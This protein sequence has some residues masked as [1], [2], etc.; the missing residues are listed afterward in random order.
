MTEG[1]D[2]RW[3]KGV[4][5]GAQDRS[6]AE[7]GALRLNLLADDLA[8]P[9]AVL[10]GSALEHNA[11]WMAEFA[12]RLGLSLAPHGKTTLSPELFELQL[13]HGAWAITAATAHHVRLYAEFGVT[14]ILMANQ[15]VGKANIAIVTELLKRK[16]ELE[17]ICLVDGVEGAT[18]LGRA[19][20]AAGLP[21]RLPVLLEVGEAGQRA[22]VRTLKDALAVARVCRSL[23]ALRLVG[24]E[25]FEGLFATA[26]GA[27]PMLDRLVEVAST[28]G[29]E[30]LFETDEPIVSA[31]GSL[32]FD[33][34]AR[35]MLRSL[36]NRP[37]RLVL[38][39]GCY[40]THDHGIYAQAGREMAARAADLLPNDG[41]VP[42]LE[43]WAHVQSRPE[44]T[45]AIANLGK[46]DVSYN[47]GL[48][49]P[50]LRFRPGVDEAPRAIRDITVAKLYDQH[51][52]PGPTGG[53]RS[54]GG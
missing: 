12:A 52:L 38:R 17:V 2:G 54:P 16:P 22:G 3:F 7:I 40:L 11:R 29:R 25:C 20:E 13:R 23:P 32:F 43:V 5:A 47:S 44:P 50:I 48:P 14:R 49:T 42:A 4:P 26:Q 9:A 6:L 45:R 15:L 1:M 19:V 28:L 46:R 35:A 31:G 34:A 53:Q 8:L 10:R 33:E 18:Q 51:A 24:V 36:D 41:L 30:G 39:S 37:A 21:A 27:V